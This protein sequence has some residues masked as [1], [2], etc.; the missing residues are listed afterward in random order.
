[1][2]GKGHGKFFIMEEIDNS[3]PLLSIDA[4]MCCVD[5]YKYGIPKGTVTQTVI[6]SEKDTDQLCF[7]RSEFDATAKAFFDKILADIDWALKLSDKIIE[8]SSALFKLSAEIRKTDVSKLTNAQLAEML[9]EWVV[10][11]KEAHGYGMAWN[12]VE[13]ENGYFSTYVTKYIGKKA[14]ETGLNLIAGKVFS[15]LSIP[16]E[17]TFTQCEQ[18]GLLQIAI[19][20]KSGEK[21][22]KEFE[23]HW[24]KYCWLSY[25]YFGP[26][27]EKS[28]FEAELSK[29][30]E[31]NRTEL[32]AMLAEKQTYFEKVGKEQEEMLNQLGFDEFHRKCVKLA[33]SFLYTKAYRKDGIYNG[34]YSL[35]GVFKECAKRLGIS[36]KQL[37]MLMSWELNAA[38]TTGKVDVAELNKRYNYRVFHYDGKTKTILSGEAAKK[39][40]N[41]LEFEKI[42]FAT[43]KEL[44][45]DCACPGNAVGFVKII[46]VPEEME[47]MQQGDILVSKA[48]TPD[49]VPAMKKAAAIVTDMGGIT[50]HAAIVSREMNIPCIIG[51]KVATKF[52]KDGDKVSVDA[53][54]GICKKVQT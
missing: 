16:L 23:E 17:K 47:K 29:L 43:L 6:K 34:F 8:T 15:L 35:E 3:H 2:N 30:L 42:E 12:Y 39:F 20:A 33:Q 13:Y 25:M 50:C 7:I 49:I 37:R 1:M 9:N 21:I 41:S 31:K 51:T 36:L 53:S 32:E 14:A 18:E 38:I 11:R 10:L 19:D 28:Y 27:W 40:F 22:E 5:A 24:K 52:F 4:K 44:K 26:A 54:K 45:G 46:N 48:T